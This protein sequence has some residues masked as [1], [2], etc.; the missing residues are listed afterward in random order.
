MLE[1]ERGENPLR[2]NSRVLDLHL[3]FVETELERVFMAVA[4]ESTISWD[5]VYISLSMAG[6]EVTLS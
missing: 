5:Y 6:V 1:D 3:W 2:C 4:I